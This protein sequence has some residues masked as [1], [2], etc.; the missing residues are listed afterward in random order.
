MLMSLKKV[1]D[2]EW[3]YGVLIIVNIGLFSWL[4]TVMGG[5]NDDLN[6]LETQNHKLTQQN[7]VHELRVKGLGVNNNIQSSII[8]QQYDMI[9][10]QQKV[11]QNYKNTLKWLRDNVLPDSLPK[12]DPDRII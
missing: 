1:L 11:I 12:V 4:G 10:Q 3:L 6:A 7:Q 8:E 5:M 2:S 9:I